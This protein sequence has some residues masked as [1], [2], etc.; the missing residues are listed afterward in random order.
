MDLLRAIGI[1]TVMDDGNREQLMAW[2]AECKTAG[3][4]FNKIWAMRNDEQA[5]RNREN[6][7]LYDLPHA[8][9]KWAPK[10][11]VPIPAKAPL[12]E[13]KQAKVSDLGAARESRKA[14]K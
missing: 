3:L 11:P 14:T 1:T 4:Y 12:T 2:R 10:H 13:P 8:R 7:A 5:A 9:G 6:R